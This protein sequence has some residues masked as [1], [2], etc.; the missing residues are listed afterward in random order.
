MI[1]HPFLLL[2]ILVTDNMVN[3]VRD[4]ADFS[5]LVTH[6]Q[7]ANF[8]YAVTYVVHK[9]AGKDDIYDSNIGQVTYALFIRIHVYI[10]NLTN[11]CFINSVY[12]YY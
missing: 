8:D 4:M 1:L 5:A 12:C 11:S 7:L 6:G 2:R 3:F 9:Y 10:H